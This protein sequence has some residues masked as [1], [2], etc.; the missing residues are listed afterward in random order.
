MSMPVLRLYEIGCTSGHDS[1]IRVW[2]PENMSLQALEQLDAMW[3]L[4]MRVLRAS[5]IPKFTGFDDIPE[6]VG[7]SRVWKKTITTTSKP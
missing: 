3:S 4:A 5:A 7:V 1:L 6:D 2:V